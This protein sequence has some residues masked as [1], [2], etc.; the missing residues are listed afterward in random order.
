MLYL[1]KELG[2]NQ[3]CIW[4]GAYSFKQELKM[5]FEYLKEQIDIVLFNI[6]ET[7]KKLAQV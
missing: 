4:P 3:Y 5:L 7:E 1:N 6:A 2:M